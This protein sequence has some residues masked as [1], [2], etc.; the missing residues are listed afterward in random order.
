MNA[1][2]RPQCTSIFS[3]TKYTSCGCFKWICRNQKVNILQL[4]KPFF[5]P[6]CGT[7]SMQ[8]SFS[9]CQL[10]LV[11]QT[12]DIDEEMM[13]QNIWAPREKRPQVSGCKTKM[14]W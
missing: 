13:W 11:Q 8:V 10:A 9:F 6:R 2:L 4:H 5:F 14:P 7:L 12:H 1:L 3:Y